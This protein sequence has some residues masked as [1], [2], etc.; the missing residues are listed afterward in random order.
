M[1]LWRR[2]DPPKACPPGITA[3]LEK[4]VRENEV[5]II[6]IDESEDEDGHVKHGIV[7]RNFS[8]GQCFIMFIQ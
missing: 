8:F 1:V 4:Y 6:T 3:Q 5:E 7:S 2:D